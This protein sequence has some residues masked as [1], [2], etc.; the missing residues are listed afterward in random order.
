ML[1]LAIA[2]LA[3]ACA[4]QPRCEL[5]NR[6]HGA[7]FLWRVQRDGG[8]IVWLFGTI[9]DAGAAEVPQAAWT[10]LDSSPQFASELGDDEPDPQQLADLARQ[11]WG[12][13]LD[14]QLPA[15]DWFDLVDAMRGAMSAD[16]LRHARPWFAMVRLNTDAPPSP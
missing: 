3:T 12:Q 1:R 16:A 5:P 8:P 9:H 2:L 7:P 15:G 14:Q 13:V 11:P 10:A 6:P 4:A